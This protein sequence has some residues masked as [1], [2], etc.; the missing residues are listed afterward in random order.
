VA[1]LFPQA[2]YQGGFFVSA[3]RT[4]PQRKE[5][6][7]FA[8]RTWWL[9]PV[10]NQLSRIITMSQAQIDQIKALTDQVAKAKAEITQKI[11]DLEAAIGS[12]DD[13]AVDAA[14][15]ELKAAV[16]GVDDIVPDVQG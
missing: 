3:V 6:A 16:Q 13:A 4:L 12:D 8:I 10:I 2:A 7:M 5:H 11:A 1:P 14:L 9:R 15:A